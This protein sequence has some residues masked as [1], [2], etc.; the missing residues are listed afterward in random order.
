MPSAI[1]ILEIYFSL[2]T[3]MILFLGHFLRAKLSKSHLG[4]SLILSTTDFCNG[5]FLKPLLPPHPLCPRLIVAM[6][7][8]T[9]C[10]LS[11]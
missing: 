7:D 2:S 6:T 1:I 5:P 3:W 11:R 10:F 8:M 9:F 4:F